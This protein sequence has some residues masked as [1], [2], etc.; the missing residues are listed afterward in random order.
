MISFPVLDRPPRTISSSLMAWL[1]WGVVCV[2]WGVTYAAIQSGTAGT[3]EASDRWPPLLFTALRY[4]SAGLILLVLTRP[5]DMHSA[6]VPR[7]LFQLT[8]AGVLMFITGNG[9]VV[10]ALAVQDAD[11]GIVAVCIAM[12]PIYTAF[13][14]S[15]RHGEAPAGYSTWA[16]LML[17]FAGIF[18]LIVPTLEQGSM[19]ARAQL[20]TVLGLQVGCLSWATGS[21]FAN[22]TVGAVDPLPAAGTQMFTAGLFMLT[23]AAVKGDLRAIPPLTLRSLE[24]LL[25]VIII[26]SV[27]AYFCYMLALQHLS[28][29]TVALHAY[30][31][32]V[33][34]VLVSI[35]M[36]KSYTAVQLLA[37]T[38]VLAGVWIAASHDP[39]RTDH[40]EPLRPPR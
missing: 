5:Q 38:I 29:R 6:R 31:N 30:L 35:V 24:P 9:F 15:W 20:V 16:G 27:V 36:G 23:F 33:V 25:F 21:L 13:L 40:V 34:A 32:P 19:S 22:R 1:A 39:S 28:V 4:T 12:I 2:A 8:A 14:T 11:P 7:H 37:G 18:L 3:V 10:W 26:G 17:S